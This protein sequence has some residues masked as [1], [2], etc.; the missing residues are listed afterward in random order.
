M[1]EVSDIKINVKEEQGKTDKMK[2]EEA[3]KKEKKTKK[4]KVDIDIDIQ[5]VD[6]ST[7]KNR[8]KEYL[9]FSNVKHTDLIMK[10]DTLK[11]AHLYCVYYKVSS[12]Q[13][14]PLLEMFL[15]KQFNFIKNKAEECIGDCSKDGKNSEIKVSLGGETFAKF[16][17]VQIRPSHE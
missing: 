14:G 10:L 9:K 12:Q 17:F 16:N 6:R 8:L 4:E 5:N 11:E 13:Y 7:V 2:S 15:Q 3:E 1:G